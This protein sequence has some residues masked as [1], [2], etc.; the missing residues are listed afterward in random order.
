MELPSVWRGVPSHFAQRPFV[1]LHGVFSDWYFAVSLWTL[2]AL[3]VSLSSLLGGFNSALCKS[4]VSAHGYAPICRAIGTAPRYAFTRCCMA[5]G[6]MSSQR[7]YAISLLLVDSIYTITSIV[8]RTWNTNKGHMFLV[9]V[10]SFSF[11]ASGKE[12]MP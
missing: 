11:P 8:I 2:E 9:L 6:I 5:G 12:E 7:T 3:G 4:C 1:G 10:I